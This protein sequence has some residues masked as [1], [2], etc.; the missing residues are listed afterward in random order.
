[1][2]VVCEA[3]MPPKGASVGAFHTHSH[4]LS[5]LRL[6]LSIHP[7]ITVVFHN[8]NL[9]SPHSYA[10]AGYLIRSRCIVLSTRTYRALAP[11]GDN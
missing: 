11:R 1:M 4:T 5:P 7:S 9:S 8:A 10:A 3:K 6:L 2:A